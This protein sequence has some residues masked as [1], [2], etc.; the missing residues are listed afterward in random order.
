MDRLTRHRTEPAVRRYSGLILRRIGPALGVIP[1]A[2]IA[3]DAIAWGVFGTSE[4]IE[5]RDLVP[6]RPWR[7]VEIDAAAPGDPC[8]ITVVGNQTTLF[9]PTES[10]R[11]HECA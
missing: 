2:R 10:V 4:Q 6:R 8:E 9:C 1:D 7:D 11:F 5:V 3:Y